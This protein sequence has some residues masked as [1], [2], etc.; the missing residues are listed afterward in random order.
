MNKT[1]IIIT[2]IFEIGECKIKIPPVRLMTE[3]GFDQ[4]LPETKNPDRT[5]RAGSGDFE[6]R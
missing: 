3:I 5:K 2:I 4:P 1:I 6:D